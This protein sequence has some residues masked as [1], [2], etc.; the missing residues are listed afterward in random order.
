MSEDFRIQF[1]VKTTRDSLLNIR[2][3]S[4]QEFEQFAAWALNN[5]AQF[6]NLESAIKGVPPALAANVTQ[7]QV[8]QE[9]PTYQPPANEPTGPA[10]SCVHG[11]MNFRSG[12]SK[13]SG[14]PYRGFF[15][16]ANQ[17]QAV[18]Q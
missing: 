18:F 10:P 12:M 15:C 7:T 13:K 14:K 9:P 11:P 17:C 2:A 8:V 6:V 1:S 3:N 4:S 16:T 5:A